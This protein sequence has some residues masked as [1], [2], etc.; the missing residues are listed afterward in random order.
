MNN[1]IH[2]YT[3]ANLSVLQLNERNGMTLTSEMP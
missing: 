2:L 1:F 3:F